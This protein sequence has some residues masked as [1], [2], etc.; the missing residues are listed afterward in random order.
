MF[1]PVC[2]E[3]IHEALFTK[4]HNTHD[5]CMPCYDKLRQHEHTACPVC[6]EPINQDLVK[7]FPTH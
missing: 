2:L 4:L 7:L 1:C 6:R 3:D 5:I